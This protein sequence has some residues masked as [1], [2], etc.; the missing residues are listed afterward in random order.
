M[1]TS[2]KMGN[3]EYGTPAEALNAAVEELDGFDGLYSEINAII[4]LLAVSYVLQVSPQNKLTVPDRLVPPG[5]V[6]QVMKLYGA[7]WDCIA[8]TLL[9]KLPTMLDQLYGHVDAAREL[10]EATREADEAA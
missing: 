5:G 4:T 8:G 7:D 10:I 2:V 9:S 1:I 3:I 6:E